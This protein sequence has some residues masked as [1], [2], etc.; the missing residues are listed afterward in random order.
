MSQKTT[1]VRL[2]SNT[3]KRL[4]RLSKT[5]NRPKSQ[6]INKAL[7][8]YLEEYEDYLIAI[9]RLHDKNDRIISEKDFRR[10]LGL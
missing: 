1:S 10:R 5:I 4:E 6:L 8:E 9:E 2:S 3:A 7:E